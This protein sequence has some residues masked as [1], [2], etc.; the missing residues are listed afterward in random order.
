VIARALCLAC[1]LAG[2]A[3]SADLGALHE[4]IA[5]PKGA[6]LTAHLGFGGGGLRH[7][8]T[9]VAFGPDTRVDVASGGSRWTIGASVMGGIRTGPVYLDARVGVWHAIT[10]TADEAT[11][12]PSF[13][14]GT[15]VPL[16]EKFDPTHPQYGSASAGLVAGVRADLDDTR[17]LTVFVGYAAFLMPGY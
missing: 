3:A 10:S 13:E 7:G 6:S 12:V 8:R 15:Y 2:C 4:P 9:V 16:H 14:L 1:A 17:Y 5:Q 11:A